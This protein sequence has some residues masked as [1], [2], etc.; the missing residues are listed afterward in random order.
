MKGPTVSRE[1]SLLDELHVKQ[2]RERINLENDII[3]VAD[4]PDQ[5]DEEQKDNKQED[6]IELAD[7][8]DKDGKDDDL[9]EINSTPS[10]KESDSEDV[11]VEVSF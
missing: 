2:T 9:V 8:S 5:K 1:L 3:V 10:N 6:V 7:E 11:E 4:E